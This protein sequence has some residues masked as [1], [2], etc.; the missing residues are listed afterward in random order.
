M[1][2]IATLSLVSNVLQVI[3][4][5]GEVFRLVRSLQNDSSLDPGLVSTTESLHQLLSTLTSRLNDFDPTQSTSGTP[6]LQQQKDKERLKTLTDNLLQDIKKLQTIV[7]KLSS[8]A[9]KGKVLSVVLKY[10][11]RYHFEIKSLERNI[12]KAHAILNTEFLTRICDS[13]SAEKARSEGAFASLD[14]KLQNFIDLWSK[15]HRE[16]SILISKEAENTRAHFAAQAS[17][18]RNQIDTAA[19]ASESHADAQHLATRNHFTLEFSKSREHEER[20]ELTARILSTLR[21]PQMNARENEIGPVLEGTTSWIFDEMDSDQTD[22]DQEYLEP[23]TERAYSR[24][25][26]WLEAEDPVFW[27]SGKPGSGKSSLMKFLVS[28]MRTTDHLNKWRPDVTIYRYFFIETG[29]HPLQREYRGCL[30]ALLYQILDSKPHVLDPLLQQK[31]N[32]AAKHSEDDWSVKELHDVFLAALRLANCPICLFLDGLDEI[33]KLD[34]RESII[35]LVKELS[36]LGDLKIC[37]SSRPENIFRSRFESFPCL[38]TQDLNGPAIKLYIS[39]RLAQYKPSSPTDLDE[40]CELTWLLASKASGVFLW[41]YLA[42]KSIIDGIQGEDSWHTLYQR[43]EELEPDLYTFFRQMLERQNA[44]T[45]FYKEDTARLLWHSIYVN[46]GCWGFWRLQSLLGYIL[47]THTELRSDLLRSV[48]GAERIAEE[49]RVAEKYRKWLSARSAGLLEI[50]KE[51]Y[52]KWP[53]WPDFFLESSLTD[54]CVRPIHRSV[55][56]FLL[57]SAAGLDILMIHRS[58]SKERLLRTA[59]AMKDICYYLAGD[60]D[61]FECYTALLF[62]LVRMGYLTPQEETEALL[63]FK[64]RLQSRAPEVFPDSY[65]LEKAAVILSTKFLSQVPEA[66]EKLSSMEKS[67]YLS[68]AC[69]LRYYRRSTFTKLIT[70]ENRITENRALRDDWAERVMERL[71]D[72]ISL[73]LRTGADLNAKFTTHPLCGLTILTTPFHTFLSVFMESLTYYSHYGTQFYLALAVYFKEF[74]QYRIDWDLPFYFCLVHSK[75]RGP[76]WQISFRHFTVKYPHLLWGDCVFAVPLRWLQAFLSRVNPFISPD[77]KETEIKKELASV[78]FNVQCIAVSC[79][80]FH[81]P[82]QGPE[83]QSPDP[84]QTEEKRQLEDIVGA[85]YLRWLYSL[86]RNDGDIIMEYTDRLTSAH[87][88]GCVWSL[89]FGRVSTVGSV[90]D[91][92]P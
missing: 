83:Y 44:N 20:E 90:V 48:V 59:E 17:M 9:S 41:V 80:G 56:E 77:Q 38:Q 76:G 45:R 71:S 60:R 64:S 22:S 73:L 30:R 11:F 26:Q 74:M 85:A 12:D 42:T 86:P 51:T 21:F 54:Y 55:G 4:F 34:D 47:A 40:Y 10:K 13:R 58:P 33:V 53:M 46:D 6:P 50:T 57:G 8:T 78:K 24:F 70:V 75:S 35:E 28:D 62:E 88:G 81:F 79:P 63:D 23:E 87:A 16:M 72:T 19:Q 89:G 29:Q 82:R 14:Q 25:T 18:L 1:E 3:S 52:K 31:P 37:A 7:G 66:L 69:E 49:I 43:T 36:R 2:A 84:N 39:N 65:L 32:L 5:T 92:A 15:G 68:K 61:L 27:I 91:L 67:F